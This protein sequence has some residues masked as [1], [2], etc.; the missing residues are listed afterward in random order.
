M[1]IHIKITKEWFKVM[2]WLSVFF[3]IVS[4]VVSFFKPSFLENAFS[5]LLLCI[6]FD[7]EYE[8][9]TL[10]EKLNEPKP[11]QQD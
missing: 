3:L 1:K 8:N 2:Y 7:L 4:V 5:L 11:P 10:T 9:E 6:I